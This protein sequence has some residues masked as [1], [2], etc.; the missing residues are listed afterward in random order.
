[1]DYD[2]SN[3]GLDWQI[4]LNDK[5][6]RIPLKVEAGKTIASILELLPGTTSVYFICGTAP[7][8]RLFYEVSMHEAK[9]LLKN[10][11]ITFISDMSMDEA[12]SSVRDLPGKS[13]I[14][15]PRFTTDI[16][17][18][19]YY[20]TEAVRLISLA[21]NAPVF[22][23]TDMGFGDGAVGGYIL[24]LN[25]AGLIT[26]DAAVK[27]LNGANPASIKYSEDD[28]YEYIFDWREL[29]RWNIAGSD[30]IPKG[31]IIMF[32][33]VHFFGKYKWIIAG[34]ILFILAQ[35]FLIIS[36]VRMY[37]RQKR[38]TLQI[39]E[40]ENKY[41]ELIREERILQIAQLTASLSHE[42]NQ[43]LTAILSNAQ[44]GIRF[45]NSGK[46]TPELMKEIFENIVED[47][48]RTASILSS[49]RGM[50]KLEER[51]K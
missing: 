51:E 41:R 14:I 26:G 17:Q 16:K 5:T 33:D 39:K 3:Y 30:R 40:T 37:R 20:N 7:G 18:V 50:M 38:M 31:S 28:Y 47:D 6:T 22:T 34:G 21:A 29:E 42:L 45:V 49:V 44:A 9:K 19:N 46:N 12:L 35:T 15:V 32:E 8:D 23:Y 11:K 25:K 27:V 1:L 43:P 10:I 24:N 48:K 4:E 2:F 36:L 13:I